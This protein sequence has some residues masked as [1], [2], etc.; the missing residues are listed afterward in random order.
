MLRHKIN[1]NEKAKPTMVTKSINIPFL[2]WTRCKLS[3][4]IINSLKGMSKL[5]TPYE[6]IEKY[7]ARYLKNKDYDEN[8]IDKVLE[9]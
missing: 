9:I 6:I 3:N 4:E 5:T 1:L 2:F 8:K 7:F